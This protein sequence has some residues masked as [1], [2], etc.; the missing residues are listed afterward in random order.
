MLKLLGK[1]WDN[2][3]A[4]VVAVLAQAFLPASILL[5]ITTELVAFFGIQSAMILPAMIFAAGILR[6]E[7]LDLE[8]ARRYRVALRVQM[9]FWA[10]L[11]A[12]DFLAVALLIA[13]KATSWTIVLSIGH[14]I[15]PINAGRVL[16]AL[17]FM[18]GTLAVLR[19]IPLVIGVL[20]LQDLNCDL[21]EAAIK[22]RRDNLKAAPVRPGDIEPFRSPEGF[23]RVIERR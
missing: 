17:T 6:P 4:A 23:G 8:A 7:G 9:Y 16:I 18:V 22:S 21:T 12:L 13:G 2:L 14:G 10:V 3:G 19:M 5:T 15:P 1:Y 20:S 11:L